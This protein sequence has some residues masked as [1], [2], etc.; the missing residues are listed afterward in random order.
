MATVMGRLLTGYAVQ[1]NRRHRHHGH[2]FQNRYKSIICQE[3]PYLLE[4]VRYIHLNPLRAGLVADYKS[5]KGFVYGGHCALMGK[6]YNDWQNT[7][8]VLSLFGRSVSNVRRSY[9]EFVKKGVSEGKRPELVGGGLMRS[10]GGWVAAK[11]FKGTK[12]RING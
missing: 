12:D 6:C 10:L 9:S 3:D 11:A 7:P 8:Y 1:F 5:L 4:L 2:V